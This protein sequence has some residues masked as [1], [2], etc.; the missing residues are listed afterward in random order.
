MD[1]DMAA[2]VLIGNL[3]SGAAVVVLKLPGCTVTHR[4]NVE[5]ATYT[6]DC[7]DDAFIEDDT[8]AGDTFAAGFLLSRLDDRI[9]ERD[10][11]LIGMELAKAKLLTDRLPS[12]AL[13]SEIIERRMTFATDAVA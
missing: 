1:D 6:I 11:A 4:A 9:N 7:L 13:L 2:Q 8:G 3:R 10:G 12:G 5:P